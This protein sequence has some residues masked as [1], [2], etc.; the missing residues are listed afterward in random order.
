MSNEHSNQT[1]V[2]MLSPYFWRSFQ[3]KALWKSV[4]PQNLLSRKKK[5]F[6]QKT[7]I[8]LKDFLGKEFMALVTATV[9]QLLPEL[10]RSYIWLHHRVLKSRKW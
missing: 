8:K 1:T 4:F 3:A 7:L 5:G 2:Y 6:C 9:L 10:Q